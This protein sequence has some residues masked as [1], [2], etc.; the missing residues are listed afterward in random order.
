MQG[1]HRRERNGIATRV[2]GGLR[3]RSSWRYGRAP[4]L[5]DRCPA[6]AR[7]LND[8][9]ALH[10]SREVAGEGA[11]ERVTARGRRHLEGGF[12]GFA[13]TGKL[14]RGDHFT[15]HRRSD[16]V[17]LAGRSACGVEL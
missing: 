2:A 4:I 12:D 13:W 5:K 15:L 6:L 11:H 7:L 14:G 16:E 17:G 10:A 3:T 1:L 9:G 8:E